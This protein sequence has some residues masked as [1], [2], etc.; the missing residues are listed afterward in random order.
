MHIIHSIHAFWFISCSIIALQVYYSR[1]IQRDSLH[2]IAYLPVQQ[3]E[4]LFC[5]GLCTLL[6]VPKWFLWC[7]IYEYVSFGIISSCCSIMHIYDTG[8]SS[9]GNKLIFLVY[10]FL[11]FDRK[12]EYNWD[13]YIPVLLQTVMLVVSSEKL[14]KTF[15]KVSTVELESL[16]SVLLLSSSLSWHLVP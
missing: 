1:T 2:S 6:F 9:L 11:Q 14:N 10:K 15:S 7:W 5:C 8:C 4:L 16:F 12:H 13:P 3:F